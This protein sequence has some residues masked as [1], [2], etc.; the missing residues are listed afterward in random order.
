MEVEMLPPSSLKVAPNNSRTHSDEQ[1]EELAALMKEFGFTN[2]ILLD[3]QH[4]IVAGHGRKAAALLLKLNLVPTI[5]LK[6]LTE[7]QMRALVIADNQIALN[8]GWD[9]DLLKLEIETLTDLNFDID[10]LGFDVGFIDGLLTTLDPAVSPPDKTPD[11]PATPCTVLGDVWILGDHRV[12]CGDSTSVDDVEKLCNGEK[13]Q[14]IHADPP[15]GMGKTKDGVEGDNIYKEELDRF[16][17]EWWQTFRLFVVDNASA[18]IW[19]NAADLWRMWYGGRIAHEDGTIEK[20]HGLS[21]GEQFEIRNEI[22]WNKKCAPGMTSEGLTAYQTGSERCL[23]FQ[24]GQQFIENVNSWD[25]WEGWDEIRGYLEQQGA[26]VSLGP[27]RCQ[28]ITRSQMYSHWFS[29]SQWTLI[30][31]PHYNALADAF[32]GYFVRPHAELRAI[33]EQLKIGYSKHMTD[34]LGIMRSYFDNT[35]DA[36]IDVWDFPRVVGN[37]RHGHATPK[38]VEMMQRI[39]RSSLPRGGLCLE[40]FAGSGSTLIGAEQTGRR[41]YTME[42]QPK[43]C[44]V[45]VKRWQTLTGREAVHADTGIAFNEMI[46]AREYS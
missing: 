7:T 13:A 16:Q 28:E 26:A 12:M 40:P 18:Y 25:Y 42:L 27:K 23:F 32:P 24:I 37:E 45:T 17:L 29:K 2:P 38:P 11:F 20:L 39:M 10:L 35:H 5:T 33:H 8:A 44:D 9:L 6:G 15:Y 22:V 41:C 1:I 3:E 19:G 21:D 31:E 46:D 4:Q 30:T 43:Y 14:L 34:K 36:M